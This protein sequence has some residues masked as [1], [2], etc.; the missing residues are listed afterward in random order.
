MVT[1]MGI[2]S[3]RRPVFLIISLQLVCSPALIHFCSVPRPR[4]YGITKLKKGCLL[5]GTDAWWFAGLCFPSGY[6]PP[7]P[8]RL[9]LISWGSWWRTRLTSPFHDTES[10]FRMC[11]YQAPSRIQ[12]CPMSARNKGVMT[13]CSLPPPPL[14]HLQQFG[15]TQIPKHCFTQVAYHFMFILGGGGNLPLSVFF[16]G[17]TSQPPC[18]AAHWET[19]RIRSALEVC[20]PHSVW[21]KSSLPCK[22]KQFE[23]DSLGAGQNLCNQPSKEPANLSS[24]VSTQNI[25]S[26]I[27]VHCRPRIMKVF[28]LCFSKRINWQSAERTKT[29][30]SFLWPPPP[31]L[32]WSCMELEQTLA[33][34]CHPHSRQEPRKGQSQPALPPWPHPLCSFWEL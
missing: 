29:W 4:F 32:I 18:Q 6:A 33:F 15:F 11:L 14:D 8:W 16:W 9:W 10:P 7:H 17:W 1:A 2:S 27:V 13:R 19:S 21:P 22:Q 25:R 20:P 12:S 34:V 5:W 30:K 24:L 3:G 28:G 26:T 23:G 31:K